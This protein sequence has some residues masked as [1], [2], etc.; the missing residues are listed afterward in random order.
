MSQERPGCTC[1]KITHFQ[2]KRKDLDPDLG[3]KDKPWKTGEK[4]VLKKGWNF[5]QNG[6]N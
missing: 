4:I 1:A 3:H 5:K 6:R 2:G